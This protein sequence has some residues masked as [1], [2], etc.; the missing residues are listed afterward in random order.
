MILPVQE[1]L[2][3]HLARVL[4]TLFSLDPETLPAV[5]LEYPPNRDLGDLGTPIA[6]E[7]ARRLRKAP[8][9]IAQD[10]AGAF[11]TLDVPFANTVGTV[12]FGVNQA[13]LVGGDYFTTEFVTNVHG[14][15]FD[16]GT[17]STIDA[18]FGGAFNTV[19]RGVNDTGELVGLYS[20]SMGTHGFLARPQAA[21]PEAPSLALLSLGVIALLAWKIQE[22]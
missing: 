20:D 17:F 12:A 9:A 18:P 5:A 4:S 14:F 16:H 22:R 21:V 2:R 10:I 3:T 8:R 6:F 1:R 13:G 7:L 11:G 19:V 15:L